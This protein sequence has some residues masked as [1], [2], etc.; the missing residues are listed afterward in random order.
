MIF[1]AILFLL[2]EYF[3]RIRYAVFEEDRDCNHDEGEAVDGGEVEVQVCVYSRL[4]SA[5]YFSH[6]AFDSPT[7]KPHVKL[8]LTA[9]S[10]YSL[11]LVESVACRHSGVC[12]LVFL[13]K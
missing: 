7:S 13:S 11:P 2:C 4:I 12:G 5:R 3:P 6:L 10:H 8:S 1:T 9:L